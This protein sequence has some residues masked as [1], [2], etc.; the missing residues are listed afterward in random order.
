[1]LI[2]IMNV[3][4]FIV[5]NVVRW[6]YYGDVMGVVDV[7]GVFFRIVRVLWLWSVVIFIWGVFL[8]D[9]LDGLEGV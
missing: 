9:M 2:F 7:V 5:L 8:V 4:L 1:M 3:M 6:D